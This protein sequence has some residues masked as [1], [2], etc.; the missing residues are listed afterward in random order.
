MNNLF[1]NFSLL[2]ILIFS[3]Y[4]MTIQ[5]DLSYLGEDLFL[6]SSNQNYL[7]YENTIGDI[8]IKLIKKLKK[9]GNDII[10]NNYLLINN[11]DENEVEFED[12]GNIYN[13]INNKII[14]CPRGKYHPIEYSNNLKEKIPNN[15]KENGNWDLKCYQN[16]ENEIQVIYLMN[17]KNTLYK[18]IN[19]EYMLDD[20]IIN[21]DELYDIKLIKENNKELMNYIGLRNGY[22]ELIN[23]NLE[24][25]NKIITKSKLY[26]KVYFD[27]N[28]NKI[29]F[30]TYNNSSDFISGYV[31]INKNNNLIDIYINNESQFNIDDNI[32][33]INFIIN[34]NRYI[35]Y[36][37][38]NNNKIYYGVLDIIINKII[39]NINEELYIFK[40]L[41]N[42]YILAI[43]SN[44]AYKI[45]LLENNN[46]LFTLNADNCYKLCYN[47]TE[48]SSDNENQKCTDCKNNLILVGEN[49]ICEQGQQLI[50]TIPACKKCSLEIEC[51]TYNLNKCTCSACYD[52]YYLDSNNRCLKCNDNCKTCSELSDKCLTCNDGYY[53]DSINH[54]C[55]K[56]KET[57]KTCSSETKCES[58]IDDYFLIYDTCYE[59]NMNCK[60]KIDRCR[61]NSC[62]D[63]FYL[64]N[65]QC[66]E[67][68][69]NCKTCL[70]SSTNCL[71]CYDEY[72]LDSNK[73]LECVSPC[74]TCSSP[75]SCKSCLDKYFIIS[76]KCYKCNLDC[77]STSDGCMCDTCNE[78]YYLINGQCKR[79]S[80]NCLSCSNSEKCLICKDG[81]YLSNNNKCLECDSNCKTCKDNSTSCTSCNKGKF[82][83][84]NECLDC[85]E[86]CQSYDQ[87]NCKCNICK[88]NYQLLRGQCNE[89]EE[90]PFHCT[91]YKIN[92]CNCNNCDDGYYLNSEYICKQC[93]DNCKTCNNNENECTSCNDHYFIINN[94]CYEC[95]GCN[96]TEKDS[97]KCIS[98]QDGTYLNKNYQ[99]IKCDT[100][101]KKCKDFKSNCIDCYDGYYLNNNLC[102]P[103]F[104]RCK[105]C[106]TQSYDISNQN[107]ISCFDNY[108]LFN[109][110]CIDECPEGYY[111]SENK[112]EKCN[113]HCKTCIIEGNEKNESCLTCDE[114]SEYK[115]L[116]NATGYGNNCV[117]NCPEGTTLN[118]NNTCI[119]SI[120]ENEDDDGNTQNLAIIISSTIGGLIIIAIVIY[121]IYKFKKKKEDSLPKKNEYDQQLIDIINKDL[122][123]YQS[124][125]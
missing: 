53:L 70:G 68:D 32:K 48:Y 95:T 94:I 78:G 113:E 111:L 82:L 31:I 47:C 44:S 13:I 12:I 100:S 80:D 69:P 37:I 97:C 5:D 6:Y 123:L 124:F 10:M 121:L 110:N 79:C 120:A 67:C 55:L 16:K 30:I 109:N 57:C 117:K 75:T 119:L 49:C 76:D 1:F 29:Y 56:C 45:S 42:E 11:N 125:T 96:E 54:K 52:G 50:D 81:Y 88:T 46:L 15:F 99:C 105:K 34:N 18:I 122:G 84:E 7:I 59:C 25:I 65:Y 20:K 104:N 8:N 102:S 22:I 60:T 83:Y 9:E 27:N 90:L 38:Y 43:N 40:P 28:E 89:C 92:T 17:G 21:L 35:Y 87:N 77:K 85:A 91:N 39:F 73:C 115:Y 86:N 61:C 103:C 93:N 112:C 33:E 36:K 118:I 72:Y 108:I 23:I 64:I 74:K 116:V 4:C 3:S 66:L 71:S 107:C 114:N 106:T 26:T 2:F 62:H 98:C 63:G 101:C 51:K 58:C 24:N 41:L 14:I 19:N